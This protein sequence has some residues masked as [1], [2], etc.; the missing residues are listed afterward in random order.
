[1]LTCLLSLQVLKISP[2]HVNL[3]TLTE[4]SR[5]Q[6]NQNKEKKIADLVLLN[7]IMRD[8]EKCNIFHAPYRKIH[9]FHAYCVGCDLWNNL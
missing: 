7:L 1:M 3:I 4:I 5:E 2:L 9:S 8:N 6:P